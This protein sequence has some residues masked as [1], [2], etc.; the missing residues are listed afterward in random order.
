MLTNISENIYTLHKTIAHEQIH[1]F[2]F[3]YSS[4]DRKQT[5]HVHNFSTYG[6]CSNINLIQPESGIMIL[7]VPLEKGKHLR[8]EFD[9]GEIWENFGFKIVLVGRIW[10]NRENL[11]Q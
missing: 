8:I 11:K 6:H 9:Y 5:F 10:S 7:S 4:F 1:N 3:S 2:I